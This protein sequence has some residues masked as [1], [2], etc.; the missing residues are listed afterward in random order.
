MDRSKAQMLIEIPS[1]TAF[2][3]LGSSNKLM[4]PTRF[5]ALPCLAARTRGL[6]KR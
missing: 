6:S 3:P 1:G 2:P 5:I 4:K